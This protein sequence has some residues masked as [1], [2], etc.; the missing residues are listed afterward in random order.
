VFETGSEIAVTVREVDEDP[1]PLDE[2][3]SRT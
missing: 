1:R 3:G 2:T